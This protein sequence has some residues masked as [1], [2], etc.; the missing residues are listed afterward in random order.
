MAATQ[1][2]ALQ[3]EIDSIQDLIFRT[4]RAIGPCDSFEGYLDQLSCDH[5][6]LSKEEH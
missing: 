2:S 3:D 1:S 6:S 5:C 4:L